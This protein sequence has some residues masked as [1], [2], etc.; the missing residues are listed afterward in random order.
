MFETIFY[1]PEIDREAIR[2][3]LSEPESQ[4]AIRVLRLK[5]GEKVTL[6]D[7]KGSA[8]ECMI[9]NPHQKRCEVEVINRLDGV[10]KRDYRVHIAIAP[11]KLNER[12]EWFLEKATEIG[13]DEVTP[14]LSQ[15]S[16]RKELK[17]ERMD[18]I[19]VAAMKQSQKAYKPILNEMMSFTDFLKKNEDVKAQKFIAHCHQGEKM[20]LKEAKTCS[21]VIVMI[22]PEGDFSE[23]EVES[24]IRCGYK[25]CTLGDSRL[26]TETAALV[27]CH[28]IHL[29][30]E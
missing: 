2:H 5:S 26:R 16:E 3:V 15:H 25:A 7:G 22:G 24:A 8:Y 28:T 1:T 29:I 19:I 6:V 30:N 17:L 9:V 18:K 21:D 4:H 11:T 27:A 20:K 13:I 12:T 23:E 14:I 10:G